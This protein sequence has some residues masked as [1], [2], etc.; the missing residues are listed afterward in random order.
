LDAAIH[1]VAEKVGLAEDGAF[2]IVHYPRTSW[3]VALRN[4]VVPKVMAAVDEEMSEEYAQEEEWPQSTLRDM[5]GPLVNLAPY[6]AGE[7][8]FLLPFHVELDPR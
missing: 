5:F 6:Q 2:Q 4:M 8:L 3:K 7:P 1:Y